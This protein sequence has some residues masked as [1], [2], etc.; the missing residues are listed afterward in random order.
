MSEEADRQAFISGLLGALEQ[1]D[2][3]AFVRRPTRIHV[4]TCPCPDCESWRKLAR[5]NLGPKPDPDALRIHQQVDAL[6]SR[7]ILSPAP[8]SLAPEG[9]WLADEPTDSE[10]ETL[11]CNDDPFVFTCFRCCLAWRA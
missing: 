2:P 11:P 7:G 10:D 1:A 8:Y 4:N 9:G 6:I 3:A 5:E